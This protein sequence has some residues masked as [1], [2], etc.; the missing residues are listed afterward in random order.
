LIGSP[1]GVKTELERYSEDLS[2]QSKDEYDAAKPHLI[3]LIDQVVGGKKQV[4]L[5]AAGHAT[6]KDG[7]KVDG[8]ISVAMDLYY[9][10]FLADPV[11]VAQEW[12]A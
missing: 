6:F 1:A 10:K 4:K 9:G 2:G 7:V 5:N 3:G 11:P 8:N 12:K